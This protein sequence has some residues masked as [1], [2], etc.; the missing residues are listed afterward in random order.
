MALTF[1]LLTL[2]LA[3]LWARGPQRT[4]ARA[5][6]WLGLLGAASAAGWFHGIVQPAALVGLLGFGFATVGVYRPP[7]DRR[8][9]L[10]AHVGFVALAAA[11]MT[12]LWPGFAN[13]RVIDARQF[14]PDALPFRLHLNFDKAA[15]GLLILAFGARLLGSWAEVRTMLVRLWPVALGTV[16]VLMGAALVSGYVRFAPKLPPETALWLWVNLCFTCVA[17][18]ALFRGYLQ[19]QLAA[20]WQHRRHG[21]A[22]A[23]GVAALAFGLAHAGGGPAYVVLST[24][25]GLGYGWAYLRTGRIEA[26]ILTHFALNTVHFLGFTY[27][28]LARS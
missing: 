6:A 24:V 12:H 21:A 11:L 26:A 22:A 20:A 23:L 8:L 3:A 15:L 10:L 14:T 19:Q 28:A 27:P 18:E 1:T 9:R 16:A 5:W 2:A 4:G 25:A 7:A 13:P 17:E